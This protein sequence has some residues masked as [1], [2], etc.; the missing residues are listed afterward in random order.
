[1]ADDLEGVIEETGMGR[2]TFMRRLVTGTV[3]AAPVVASF[4]MG[5]I[6]AASASPRRPIAPFCNSNLTTTIHNANQNQNPFEEVFEFFERLICNSNSSEF[7][8]LYP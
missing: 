5:G 4:A 1:M 7:G 3:F 8:R 2:R 6:D